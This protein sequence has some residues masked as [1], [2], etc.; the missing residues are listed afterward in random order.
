MVRVPLAGTLISPTIVLLSSALSPIAD[1]PV[2]GDDVG[3]GDDVLDTITDGHDIEADV[4]RDDIDL[5]RQ[6]LQ[7]Q[8]IGLH[9]L[10]RGHG[11]SALRERLVDNGIVDTTIVAEAGLVRCGYL[12]GM[13][14][15]VLVIRLWTVLIAKHR[16]IVG[17]ACQDATPVVDGEE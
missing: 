13:K 1:I 9:A 6:A 16:H 8:V 5:A 10:G 11:V 15:G 12:R 4:E 14:D 3:V 2:V 17:T 7:E